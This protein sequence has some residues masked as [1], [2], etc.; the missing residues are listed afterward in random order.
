MLMMVVE[1]DS[2]HSRFRVKK[3][4]LDGASMIR[5]RCP[6]CDGF[7]LVRNPFM[8]KIASV[9]SPT[10]P[11]SIVS[12]GFPAATD[13]NT[14]PGKSVVSREDAPR[15]THPESEIPAVAC[16]PATPAAPHPKIGRLEDL[17]PYAPPE[18]DPAGN[19]PPGMRVVKKTRPSILNRL[20]WVIGILSFF[21]GVGLFAASGDYNFGNFGGSKPAYDVQTLDSY[22]LPEAV[23]GDLFIITGKVKNV[24]KTSSR[25]IRIRAILFGKGDKVLMEQTSVAGNYLDNAVLPYMARPAI[26]VHLAGRS[27]E[28]T[29]NRNIPPENSLQFIVVC[30]D[31]PEKV[32]R[33]KV[34]AT[35]ADL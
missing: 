29:G 35:D 32:E 15:G 2:C 3:S 10:P 8:Q 34:L 30:F 9:P 4:L 27:M 6:T 23:A 7:I 11:A 20:A 16:R 26:E 21:A 17:V 24:G 19:A 18:R 5:F 22:F 31:P 14:E 13:K 25:G 1:C 33:F 28:G 12:P